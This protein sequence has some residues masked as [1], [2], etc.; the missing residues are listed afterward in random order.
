M[1]KK[2]PGITGKPGDIKALFLL[3]YLI[4]P[5]IPGYIRM[6]EHSSEHSDGPV[7]PMFFPLSEVSSPD[8]SFFCSFDH[9]YGF[10][11]RDEPL[12]GAAVCDARSSVLLRSGASEGADDRPGDGAGC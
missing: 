8:T 4:Y 5:V 10:L 2:S 1:T 9:R 12:R 6:Y 11:P 7:W 3:L